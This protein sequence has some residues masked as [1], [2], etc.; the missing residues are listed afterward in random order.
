MRCTFLFSSE[1][2]TLCPEFR[3]HTHTSVRKNWER[4]LWIYMRRKRMGRIVMIHLR[5]IQR[6]SSPVTGNWFGG[7]IGICCLGYVSYM[8]FLSS[9][10]TIPPLHVEVYERLMVE[11][12]LV[13]RELREWLRNSKWWEI[14]LIVL[15]F[16]CFSLGISFIS[17]IM[18]C[19]VD[20][21]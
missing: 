11:L 17:F 13:L 21:V 14:I 1:D 7:L 3:T 18:N 8:R 15:L 2:H 6:V 19:G 12:I 16:W 10:G 9:I 4:C 5:R 20:G